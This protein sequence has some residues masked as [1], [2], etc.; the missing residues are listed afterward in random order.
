VRTIVRVSSTALAIPLERPFHWSSGAQ[1]GAN[2]VL[3]TVELDDGTCG[4]GESTTEEPAAT[5]AFGR[6][7]AETF[8]GRAPGDIEAALAHLWREGR[9][10]ST[11]HWT[12]SI[13]GG[14]EAACW[15]ALG[16]SLGVPAS[17]FLGGRVRD[18]VDFMGF[19]QGESPD[20]LARHARELAAHG[21]RV[22]YIKIGRA[23][24]A[25]EAAVEQVRDAIGA[26]VLL[27]VDPNEAW[28]VPTA[29]E[30]IR[31]LE[32]YDLDWVEQPVAA[33]DVNGLALVRRSV[34]TKIAA[35][36]AVYTR[37]ELLHVLEKEAA[38]VVVLGHHE[39]GGLWRMRDMA[40]LANAHGLPFNRHAMME[41]AI[42]TFAGMQVMSA[43]PNL[44][45]GNQSMHQL[46]AESLV[47]DTIDVTGG[48]VR[49]P[50]GPGL[51]FELDLEAVARAHERHRLQ[52]AYRAVEP[53]HADGLR[54]R[55]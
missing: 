18:E 6:L 28:D 12:N 38:D 9:W 53:E 20:E 47:R 37:D 29:V 4:Y 51:G 1:L 45:L 21:C 52:G 33:G 24:E 23:P 39:S 34:E 17:S 41:S 48:H 26:D 10:R 50:D 3:W 19:A 5:E 36:Q 40:Q 25:D 35:D 27:R 30:R 32:A 16:K 13:V 31:A 15:D 49:V 14:I 42:S 7:I 43:V 2:L 46:L 8:V 11:P 54:W 22:V 55:P 44:T